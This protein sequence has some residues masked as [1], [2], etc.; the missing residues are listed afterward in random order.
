MSN[1]TA[2]WSAH[3]DT[4]LKLEQPLFACPVSVTVGI[5]YCAGTAGEMPLSWTACGNDRQS[6][7]AFSSSIRWVVPEWCSRVSILF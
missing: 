2:Q 3:A 7:G 4:A 1:A 6:G 5:L